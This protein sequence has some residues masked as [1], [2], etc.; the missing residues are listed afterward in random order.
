[1]KGDLEIED[2]FVDYLVECDDK[3]DPLRRIAD[4]YWD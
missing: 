1:M 2:F 3:D 4:R